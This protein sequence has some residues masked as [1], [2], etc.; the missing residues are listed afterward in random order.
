MIIQKNWNQKEVNNKLMCYTRMKTCSRKIFRTL[1]C[2]WILCDLCEHC[3]TDWGSRCPKKCWKAPQCGVEAKEIAIISEGGLP[4][5]SR[6]S[7]QAA[8]ILK[9]EDLSMALMDRSAGSQASLGWVLHKKNS[10]LLIELTKHASSWPTG[11]L[12]FNAG[13]QGHSLAVMLNKV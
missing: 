10:W 2:F 6:H 1:N 12:E 13:D 5:P 7:P 3:N 11:K 4:K 8:G 9:C